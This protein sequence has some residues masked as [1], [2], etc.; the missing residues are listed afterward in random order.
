METT[1]DLYLRVRKNFTKE[2]IA[3]KIDV[4]KNTVS[5]WEILKSVPRHYHIDLLKIISEKIDY[6]KFTEKEKDQF[7]TNK[8]TVKKCLDIFKQKLIELGVD[9][10]EYVFIEP[11]AGDGS[12]L[13]ELPPNRR[14]GLDIES[15]NSEI[16][17]TDFLTWR[18]DEGKFITLGNPPFGLRGNLALR[19]INH[20]AKF[21]DFVAFILPQSFESKG[22]GNCMD[23]V[24]GLSLI[25]SQK[26]DSSF[27]YPNGED[28]SVNVIFQIWSKNHKSKKEKKSVSK[29]IK[30]YSVSN[31]GT[32]ATTR[33][34]K[35]WY[36]CD[37][38]LP[39]TCFKDDMK[40]YYNFNELP[41]NR[42]YGII[43]L[44]EKEKVGNIIK[45]TDWKNSSFKSTNGAYNLRFDLIEN[46]LIEKGFSD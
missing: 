12:F 28:V 46:V 2:Q 13:F 14:I 44:E 42:G 37:F 32:P 10:N 19:F 22:K 39:T 21:S 18:P 34:Q 30:I 43:L 6:S 33:N 23:R 35:Y 24:N 15:K 25:H 1:Y 20:A 11:S 45:N 16:I 3:S 4:N 17:E 9:E 41:Q 36:K 8:E 40:L 26:V 29:Y 7:F 31:G 5:R 38:Y 27:Y